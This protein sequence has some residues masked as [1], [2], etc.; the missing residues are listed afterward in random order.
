MGVYIN[1]NSYYKTDKNVLS[2]I[3]SLGIYD[4]VYDKV[5]SFDFKKG[6]SFWDNIILFQ[7]VITKSNEFSSEGLYVP[8]R[9][10]NY[11]Q[12]MPCPMTGD[13]IVVKNGLT[14]EPMF[15]PNPLLEITSFILNNKENI[16]FH[17]NDYQI[18]RL[19]ETQEIEK[20]KLLEE[21]CKHAIEHNLII[22]MSIG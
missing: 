13:N 14:I 10:L 2:K 5:Q 22:G 1:V 7:T 9:G 8:R 4:T 21:L 3:E 11:Y 18:T 16:L 12:L 17:L 6:I 20:L 19:K 15:D